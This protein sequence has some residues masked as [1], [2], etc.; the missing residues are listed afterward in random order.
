MGTL[1][2]P[3]CFLF[4]QRIAMRF[5]FCE[6]CWRTVNW[7]GRSPFRWRELSEATDYLGSNTLK[8]R[9][10]LYMKNVIASLLT[11]AHPCPQFLISMLI[12]SLPCAFMNI[13][14]GFNWWSLPIP[15]PCVEKHLNVGFYF[16]LGQV[17]GNYQTQICMCQSSV[18]HQER[19]SV[20][21]PCPP[22][23][24]RTSFCNVPLEWAGWRWGSIVQASLP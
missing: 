6:L 22:K 7:S 10:G 15:H 23:K 8:F 4:R 11:L 5:R 21:T 3:S 24:I 17:F 12:W 18:E 9:E 16:T 19:F 13:S 14:M 20:I 1:Y 2:W